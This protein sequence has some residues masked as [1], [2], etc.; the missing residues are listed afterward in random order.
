MSVKD[1]KN[2][3]SKKDKFREEFERQDLEHEIAM[4]LIEAR[5]AKGLT[6]KGLAELV[7]TT[8][9]SIAR[10][11][12]GNHL[13]NLSF[14]Q[15]VAK[16]LDT[17]LV[18]PTFGFLDESSGEAS[19][20]VGVVEEGIAIQKSLGGFIGSYSCSDVASA[21]EKITIISSMGSAENITW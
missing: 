14:L 8:Q 21:V 12:S 3:L 7:G 1:I 18:P 17:Y 4:T 15:K 11:E 10:A 6:Q 13:P 16:S 2:K 5:V 19:R 20:N 9:S